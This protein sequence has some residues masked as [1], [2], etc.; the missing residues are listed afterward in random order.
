MLINNAAMGTYLTLNIFK[1]VAI[2]NERFLCK[3]KPKCKQDSY[4]T[5]FGQIAIIEKIREIV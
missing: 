5:K 4:F 2:D 3:K 1:C